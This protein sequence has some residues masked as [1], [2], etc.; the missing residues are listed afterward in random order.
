MSTTRGLPTEVDQK[1]NNSNNNKVLKSI[2]NRKELLFILYS[3]LLYTVPFA[4][5]LSIGRKKTSLYIRTDILWRNMTRM[6]GVSDCFDSR[7]IY[8]SNGCPEFE[9]H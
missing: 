9:N 6:P 7:Y 4:L 5:V 3:V 2:A 1:P 8:I